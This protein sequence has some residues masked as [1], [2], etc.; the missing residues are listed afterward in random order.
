MQYLSLTYAELLHQRQVCQICLYQADMNSMFCCVDDCVD[1]VF[2]PN[3]CRT[4]SP[5]TGMS[6]LFISSWYEQYV[7]KISRVGS[8]Y[9]HEHA[10]SVCAFTIL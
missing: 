4:A 1:A 10:F 6:N 9:S 8:Q 7:L 5:E 2:E 3:L